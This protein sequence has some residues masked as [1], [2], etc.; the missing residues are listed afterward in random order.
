MKKHIYILLILLF[1]ISFTC[2]NDHK[3]NNAKSKKD[4]PSINY[5][6][7]PDYAKYYLFNNFQN[8]EKCIKYLF[9]FIKNHPGKIEVLTDKD[10]FEF[11][12]NVLSKID[13]T[14]QRFTFSR[15]LNDNLENTYIRVNFLKAEKI[16]F[17]KH[18]ENNQTFLSSDFETLTVNT[19]QNFLDYAE[20][21]DSKKETENYTY[22]L[23]NKDNQEKMKLKYHDKG[24]WFEVEIL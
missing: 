16:I 23:Y 9:D 12:D 6:Y 2:C 19:V 14:K 18:K 11:D 4:Y 3:S 15:R 17:Q 24:A 1:S 21:D 10:T 8:N 7:S 22:I 13:T 5:L 20:K